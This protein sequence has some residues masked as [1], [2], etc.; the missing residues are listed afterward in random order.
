[1]STPSAALYTLPVLRL[2]KVSDS[3][4]P[5]FIL[6]DHQVNGQRIKYWRE[7][8][9][10]KA[11]KWE[12]FPQFPLVLNADGSPWAPAC[13]W[14]LDRARA[15]PQRLTSLSSVAQSLR[16]YKQFLDDFG[17]PWDDFSQV[18]KYLRPTY[19]YKTHLQG[20]IN[21]SAIKHSTASRRMSAVVGL[22]RYVM[23]HPR[24][25]FKPENSPWAD[26][27]LGLELR[28]S[29][30]FKQFLSVT[31]TDISITAPKRDY[32]WDETIA[33]GGKL[34]P[35]P[36]EEQKALVKALRKLGNPEY[37][38]MHYVALLTGARE[39]TVLTLRWGSFKLPPSSI[40]QWP[41]KIQC[42]PG[43]LVDTKND[44]SSVYLA[45]PKP[46]YEW[47]HIYALSARA[48]A[49][50][51]KSKKQQ[52]HNNYLFL[53]NQGGPYYESKDDRHAMRHDDLFLRRS[54]P[55]G[56]NLRS[57]ITDQAIPEVRKAIPNFHYRFHDLRATFGM[58]WVDSVL[59]EK[60]TPERYSWAREQLRKI[61]WHKDASTTD[62]YI[63]YRQ[64]LHQLEQ[65]QAGW[66]Q[67]LVDLIMSA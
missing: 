63:S 10:S 2:S 4:G 25:G 41:L 27:R 1:M 23:E 54:S 37:E 15:K 6:V 44:V 62:R 67:D 33:D 28:D 24:M 20:L 51:Q 29:K 5:D 60:D 30:G 38:L 22:Y 42:G 26:Q 36:T 8:R 14:L 16:D 12:T 7:L 46:L 65:A 58:N 9:P 11:L 48:N 17:L 18:D 64:H 56:Q 61:M 52:D 55:T 40:S 34:R 57:F 31:T 47:L 66:N 21:R 43:T 32:A 35:L 45:I 50:R 3:P 39:Q 49:R 53:S 59:G 13:L 19:L